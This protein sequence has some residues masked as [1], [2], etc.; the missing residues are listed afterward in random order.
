MSTNYTQLIPYLSRET[1]EYS[2]TLHSIEVA[3]ADIFEYLRN[4]VGL[5]F[6]GPAQASILNTL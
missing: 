5:D 1:R 6:S 4:K 3:F 2:T